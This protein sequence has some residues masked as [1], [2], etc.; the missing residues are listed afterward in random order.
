LLWDVVSSATSYNVYRDGALI[1]TSPIASYTD[2][3]A[4]YGTHTYNVTSLF[5]GVESNKSNAVT[6]I[7][8]SNPVI[9]SASSYV[10]GMRDT[11]TASD[12]TFTTTGKSTPVLIES[13]AL[14]AGLTFTDNGDGTANFSGMANSG[15]N[16][17]YPITITATNSAGSVLQ[18]FTLT[19]TSTPSVPTSTTS[20]TGSSDLTVS[21]GGA[22]MPITITATGY[23]APSLTEA[24]PLPSGLN[25]HDNHNG[26][27]TISGTPSGNAGGLYT[28]TIIATNGSS[29]YSQTYTIYVDKTAVFTSIPNGQ[30]IAI[31]GQS[32]SVAI[33]T[34]GFPAPS[35]LASG[36]LPA[37]LIF[38]DNGDG[39]ATIS[40]TPQT[41]TGG[42]YP[43][44]L[45]ATNVAGSA[46][47]TF[48][49]KVNETTAITSANSNTIAFGTAMT[50]FTVTT[51]GY[52]A[53]HLTASALPSGVN[54]HDNGDGTAT[55]SGTPSGNARGT[56]IITLTA[57]NS[58][59]T[60][61]QTFTLVVQ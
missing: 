17:V 38:T 43:L 51:T 3:S 48:T 34:V 33:S 1:G 46:A 42:A 11:I 14:P 35:I 13:G 5:S 10:T 7:Y 25:F 6:V 59:G 50:P 39:T 16:G 31:V 22:I 57:T 20:S 19:I 60:T 26:T 49:L 8:G 45:T 27:A 24:S 58:V 15:T 52:P 36:S 55:I 12:F 61:T 54:F 29:S 18:N 2:E 44:T 23:P 9:T 53:P 41:G 4:N 30:Q 21:F 47:Y 32:Y 37:G 40:G 56:H 28:I